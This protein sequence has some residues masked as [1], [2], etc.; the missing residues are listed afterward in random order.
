[1]K[2]LIEYSTRHPIS[3]LMYFSLVLFLGLCSL[4]CLNVS[5]LPQTKDRWILVEAD[6]AGVRAEEIRKLVAIPLEENLSSL[7]GVKNCESVSRDGSCSLKIELKWNSDARAAL[8]EANAIIDSAMESLPEDCPK[9]RAKIAQDD[10]GEICVCVIPKNKDIL[11]AS[12]FAR[13]ELRTKILALEESSEA[14]LFGEQKREIQIVVDSRLCA[15]YDLSLEEIAQSVNSSN[16]D[17]PAGSLIEG[18][19][20]ILFKTEGSCKSFSDILATPL[21]AKNGQLRLGDIARVNCAVKKEKAFCFRNLDQCVQVKIFCKKGRNPLK[22]GAKVKKLLCEL[23]AEKENYILAIESDSSTEILNAAANLFLSALSGFLISYALILFFFR[24]FK[25]AAFIALSIPFCVLFS[26]L[27]LAALGRSANLI[28]MCGVTICLGMIID[29]SIVAMES[30]VESAK[31]K[32]VPENVKEAVQKIALSN[33]ASTTTTIAAFVPIFFIG[34][35]L[36]ELFCDLGITLISGMLFSLLYSFTALPAACVLFLGNQNERLTLA[37]LSALKKKYE[38]LLKRT[39]GAKF[40]C[41]AVMAL[42]FA[43]AILFLLPIKKELQ[44]KGRERSVCAA[45]TFA[46]GSE[47]G[48]VKART[49]ALLRQLSLIEGAGEITAKGGLQYGRLEDLSNPEAQEEKVFI[50]IKTKKAKKLA[51]ECERLFKDFNLDYSFIKQEDLI[52]RHLSIANKSLYLG[53]EPKELLLKCERH[54]NNAFVPNYIKDEIF[55]KADKSFMEK[56]N[57]SPLELARALKSSFD[58]YE[59]FPYYEDGKELSMKVQHEENE[60]SS[61]KNLSALKI[62]TPKGKFSLSTLGSWEKKSGEGILYRS[63]GK[64]AK[65]ILEGDMKKIPKEERKNTVSLKDENM[66]ELI[67][68]AALL[69]FVS[70][71]LLYCVLGAQTESFIKPLFFFLAVPPAFFGAAFCLFVF[72]SSLN[73]N[74][75]LAFAALFGLSVNNSIILLE[76]G[77][78]KFSSVLATSA[79][80]IASLLPFAFDPLK[81]NPQSSLALALAGGLLF[82]AAA[83]LILIPNIKERMNGKI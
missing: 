55:F 69:L 65:I 64:D 68:N 72:G 16:Y 32:S 67:K 22:M 58:G 21:K 2:K 38:G 48:F 52:S 80:S 20:E 43:G 41:P 9:P 63:R 82:S 25:A 8:L 36:G 26:F 31:G 51:Q 23:Q 74:S 59:T 4:F 19:Y 1:M 71:V 56:A 10:A 62:F 35:I 12:D 37:D 75:I 42:S 73:I 61:E 60:L 7:K 5:L 44:P 30:A 49:K 53:E 27:T 57:L 66:G 3:V 6:Y 29:N 13:D 50:K 81:A 39:K 28:S 77:E 45:I 83:S 14:E 24:S 76:G 11:A 34:G 17:Y 78:K 40:L 18:Q 46:P 47:I 79:T 70:L 54:F 33:S 15:R